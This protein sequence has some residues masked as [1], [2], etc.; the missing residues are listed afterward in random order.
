MPEG[1]SVH[2]ACAQLHAAL[3]GGEV[4][5]ADLR[6]PRLSTRDLVGW[7][8]SEVVPRGKHILIR[9]GAPE[10]REDLTLHSHLMM[11]GT[12]RV[13]D[14]ADGPSPSDPPW[15]VPAHLVRIVL[16]VRHP[17]GRRARALAVEVQQVRLVRRSEEPELVGHLGP[18]LLA[19]AWGEAMR[20]EAVRR[21]ASRPDRPLGLALLEQRNLAGIGNIY[22]SEICFLRGLHPAAPVSAEA[23]LPAMVDLAHRLLDV[24]RD[25]S[26]RVTTGGMMGP[27]ADLWVYDRARQPCRRCRT[28]IV[29]EA[30]ADPDAPERQERSIYVCPRCQG[31]GE[32][33]RSR[34]R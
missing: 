30:L 11:D 22:R 3:A 28:R 12:W 16:E 2:R 15:R 24:N 29:R 14:L 8:V 6:V 17:D 23:D 9:L 25:R 33:G 32:G 19:P 7:T 26:V 1:D 18:D 20:D 10:E 31:V 5:V 34:P 27:R 21:L 13:E 4:V